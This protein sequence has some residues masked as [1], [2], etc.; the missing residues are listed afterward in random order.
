MTTGSRKANGLF[1]IPSSI[2]SKKERKAE[3]SYSHFQPFMLKYKENK[4]HSKMV[5]RPASINIYFGI[6]IDKKVLCSWALLPPP[7][8]SGSLFLKLVAISS[9]LPL[10]PK[11]LRGLAGLQLTYA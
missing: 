7:V 5:C 9:R 10:Y 2:Q 11:P 4:A 1:Q 8:S 3:K 6:N